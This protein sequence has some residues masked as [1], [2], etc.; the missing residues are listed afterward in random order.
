M[1]AERGSPETLQTLQI[2]SPGGTSIPLL[3]FASVRYEL[4]QPLVWRRDRKPTINR[5]NGIN[6]TIKIRTGIERNRFTKAPSARFSAGA[7]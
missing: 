5:V 7:S 1:D 2:L 3:A 4:E 6:A